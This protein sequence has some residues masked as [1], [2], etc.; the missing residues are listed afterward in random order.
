MN[1]HTE[2]LHSIKLFNDNVILEEINNYVNEHVIYKPDNAKDYWQ[3]LDESMNLKTGDCEDMAMAKM[4]LAIQIGIPQ[5]E[6]ILVYCKTIFGNHMVLLHNHMVYDNLTYKPIV[7]TSCSY[8][9][10]FGFNFKHKYIVV[11]SNEAWAP[12]TKHF[13]YEKLD[14]FIKKLK[15]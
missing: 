3:T 12:L 11:K 13:R 7:D 15:L 8:I 9:P 10:V 1:T 6:L 14:N 2:F 4:Q 5:S